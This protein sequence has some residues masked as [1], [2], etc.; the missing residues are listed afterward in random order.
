MGNYQQP[1]FRNPVASAA[2]VQTESNKNPMNLTWP[3]AAYVQPNPP[4]TPPQANQF[5]TLIGSLGASKI[6]NASGVTTSL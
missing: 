4:S 3:L 2:T 6:T 1:D 5:G